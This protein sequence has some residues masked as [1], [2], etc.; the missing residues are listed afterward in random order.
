MR[1]LAPLGPKS[2]RPHPGTLGENHAEDSI[3]GKLGVDSLDWIYW[4]LEAEERLG[5]VLSD[6]QLERT[7]TVGEFIR[8][9]R[10]AGANPAEI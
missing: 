10:E 5:V 8:A 4:P 3:R 2:L 9:L 6:E 1:E 7:F